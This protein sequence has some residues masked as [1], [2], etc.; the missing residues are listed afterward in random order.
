MKKAFNFDA[1]FLTMLDPAC[2]T[3]NIALYVGSVIQ[4]THIELDEKGTKAAAVTVI[5]MKCEATCVEPVR[6][7]KEVILN[8]PFAFA[9][10]DTES[11]TPVF[12]GIVNTVNP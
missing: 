4:K 3:S 6:E 5:D 1:D 8:R 12:A 11:G 7:K 2:D 9:I 10:V